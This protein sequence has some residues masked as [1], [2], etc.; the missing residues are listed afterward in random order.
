MQERSSLACS[1]PCEEGHEKPLFS[2]FIKAE[3][4]YL[5]ILG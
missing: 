2:K 3:L 5:K 4:E 1:D